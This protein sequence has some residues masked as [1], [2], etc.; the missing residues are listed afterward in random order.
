[1][2]Y[3]SARSLMRQKVA[4][5]SKIEREMLLGDYCERV[6]ELVSSFTEGKRITDIYIIIDI[7]MRSLSEVRYSLMGESLSVMVPRPSTLYWELS[8]ISISYVQFHLNE[9][10]KRLFA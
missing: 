1:M 2:G 3:N 9:S 10:I 8:D 7:S 5:D 4:F 6:I